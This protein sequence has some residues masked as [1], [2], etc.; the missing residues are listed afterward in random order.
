ME[1]LLG[2]LRKSKLLEYDIA[3]FDRMEEDDPLHCYDTLLGYIA[4]AIIRERLAKNR[5]G[6]QGTIGISVPGAPAPTGRAKSKAKAKAKSD[7]R[8]NGRDQSRQGREGKGE[9]TGDNKTS[10]SNTFFINFI[11]G[12][13]EK[14]KDCPRKRV[15]E[16]NEKVLAARAQSG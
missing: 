7:G 5:K 2:H 14:G 10:D 16:A 4:R 6:A 9:G 15:S 8:K 13:C 12:K 1:V 11:L 3:L